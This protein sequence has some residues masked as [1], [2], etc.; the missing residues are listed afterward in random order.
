ML[1]IIQVIRLTAF[2]GLIA[3]GLSFAAAA[4]GIP[5]LPAE[6]GSSSFVIT[7]AGELYGWGYN[8]QGELGIGTTAS[9]VFA[10]VLIQP[11]GNLRGWRAVAGGQTSAAIGDDGNLYVWGRTNFSSSSGPFQLPPL[12]VPKLSSVN[13]WLY[14]VSGDYNF[15]PIAIADGNLYQWDLRAP[16]TATVVAKLAGVT[17][18]LKVT[19]GRSYYLVLASNGE[20]FEWGSPVNKQIGKV[21]R[22][23][24]VTRWLD[25]SS[26]VHHR[27]ALGNNGELYGWDYSAP[28]PAR[29]VR[30]ANVRYWKRISAGY[31]LSAAIGSDDQL[32]IWQSAGSQPAPVPVPKS[33]RKWVS[34]AAGTGVVLMIGDD[35]RLYAWGDNTWGQLGTET[36]N[37]TVPALVKKLEHLCVPALPT[38]EPGS[39]TLAALH[40]LFQRERELR[41]FVLGNTAEPFV[42]LRSPDLEHWMPIFTNAPLSV[43]RNLSHANLEGAAALFYRVAAP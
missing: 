3:L 39:L 21:S 14:V 29:E 36:G 28:F 30:P 5:Y 13:R 1:M 24:G 4:P 27:L 15:W 12:L 2:T 11:P 10:P 9:P 43:W 32:Y 6:L 19:A 42:L 35:C 26:G 34:M 38:S 41:L 7:A 20:L 16:I 17:S 33:V 37:L 22:P 8:Q 25:A 31:G 18:W 40:P 23:E